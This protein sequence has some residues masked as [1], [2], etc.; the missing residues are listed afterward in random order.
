MM[1]PTDEI[2]QAAET[3]RDLVA[4]TTPGPWRAYPSNGIYRVGMANSDSFKVA[5][6]GR[7]AHDYGKA[8]AT[9]IAAMSPAVARPL[10]TLLESVSS[11]VHPEVLHIARWVNETTRGSA[12][13]LVDT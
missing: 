4:K 1:N 13:G 10:A 6:T 3:L 5:D 9:W 7:H 8:D 11:V 12:Q 2:R